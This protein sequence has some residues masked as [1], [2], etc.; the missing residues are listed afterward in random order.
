MERGHA[1]IR[2]AGLRIKDDDVIEDL[3]PLQDNLL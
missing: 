2:I 3:T 1:F